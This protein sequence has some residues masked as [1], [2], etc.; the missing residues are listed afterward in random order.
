MKFMLLTYAPRDFDAE[1]LPDDQREWLRGI[2]A[3]M[4]EL[5][6][7]LEAAGELVTAEGLTSGADARTVRPGADGPVTTDGPFAETK[8]VLAGFWIVDVA[9]FDRVAE[10]ASRIVSYV[11]APIEIRPV[12]E[13]PQV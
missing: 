6:A 9:D 10:I 1:S 2:I 13:A 3:F 12:G 7:D 8:E 11:N 5:N 4:S